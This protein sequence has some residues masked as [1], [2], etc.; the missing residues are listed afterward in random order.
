MCT[1]PTW[2]PIF[3]EIRSTAR[4]RKWHRSPL[5]H[6]AQLFPIHLKNVE[7]IRAPHH[8]PEWTPVTDI[9]IDGRKEDMVKHAEEAN[10]EVQIFTDSS[11]HSSGIG[12]AAILRRQGREDKILHFYLGSETE[13]TVYTYQFGLNLSNVLSNTGTTWEPQTLTKWTSW[14][15]CTLLTAWTPSV[16]AGSMYVWV[17]KFS[18]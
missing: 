12:A 5:H 11:G 16:W 10:E 4:Q 9:H 13:H 3:K 17:Y 6:L 14:C 15:P 7:E 1:L 18:G 8:P 2:N